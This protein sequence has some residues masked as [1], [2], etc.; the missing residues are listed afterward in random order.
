MDTYT[1]A[2]EFSDH[3]YSRGLRPK[4]LEFYKWGATKL[5]QSQGEMR[6]SV[7]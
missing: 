4:T 1:L 2:K 5:N 6:R 3:C 7:G